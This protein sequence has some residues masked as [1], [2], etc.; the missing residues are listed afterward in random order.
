MLPKDHDQSGDGDDCKCRQRGGGDAGRKSWMRIHE[1]QIGRPKGF[2]EIFD[3]RDRRSCQTYPERE[4]R[5][6]YLRLHHIV[7][8]RPSRRHGDDRAHGRHC[9]PRHLLPNQSPERGVASGRDQFV[10]NNFRRCDTTQGP[11]IQQQ[12]NT[13]ESNHLS[14]AHQSQSIGNSDGQV[15]SDAG[16]P[17]IPAIGSQRE[18][19]EK[20]AEDGFA[21]RDPR[22]RLHIDRMQ[23]EE[24]GDRQAAPSQA[25]GT[26]QNQKQEHRVGRMEK[27]VG[28]MVA[29]RLQA[30]NLAIESIR[31]PGHRV[32]VQSVRGAKSPKGGVPGESGPNLG[33]VRNVNLVV[34]IEKGSASGRVIECNRRQSKQQAKD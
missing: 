1:R 12:K 16:P 10:S 21:F 34:V 33:I 17:R 28:G 11:V 25:R 4:L 32:P 29:V 20:H 15:S 7:E 24:R 14:L 9:K 2:S 5:S 31:Q 27:Y 6:G 13:R 26:L 30:E 23:S 22:H 3:I 19:K 18:E 8:S